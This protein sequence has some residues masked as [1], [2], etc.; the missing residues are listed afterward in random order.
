M[1]TRQLNRLFVANGDTVT[2]TSA[3]VDWNAAAATWLPPEPRSPKSPPLGFT[4][5]AIWVCCVGG[6]PARAGW[7]D[8]SSPCSRLALVGLL[9]CQA[10][11]MVR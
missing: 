5:P 8:A 3:A 2:T 4:D 7:A 9:G 10:V 11:T 1:S 6:S